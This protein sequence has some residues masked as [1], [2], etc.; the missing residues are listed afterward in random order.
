MHEILSLTDGLLEHEPTTAGSR[1]RSEAEQLLIGVLATQDE[2]VQM[3]FA[4][5]L[6]SQ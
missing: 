1:Q 3:P 2:R 5:S 6:V 4:S